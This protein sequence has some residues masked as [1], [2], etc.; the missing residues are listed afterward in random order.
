MIGRRLSQERKRLKLNQ[1]DVAA[2]L[3]MSRSMISMLESDHTRLDV[4]RLLIL[5]HSGFDVLKVL[6]DEPG[7]VASGRLLNWELCLSIAEHVD[8][9][10]RVRGV[11]MAK[12]KKAIV[13]KH[14]YLQ[15]AARG[16]INEA[17]LN[18]TLMMAV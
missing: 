4:G 15:F 12:E 8:T 2:L 3:G 9:W 6:T 10:L 14:L 13:T 1:A 17:V 7:Q 5:G 16:Q 18:E 11:E